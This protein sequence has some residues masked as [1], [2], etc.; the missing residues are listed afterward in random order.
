MTL[1]RKISF[2]RRE[3]IPYEVV[4]GEKETNG[5]ELP[6]HARS[7]GQRRPMT[8]EALVRRIKEDCSGRPEKA[9]W[10]SEQLSRRPIFRG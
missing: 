9:L 5:G 3:W 8:M 4:I 6:V 7:D 1:G 10:L 2:S